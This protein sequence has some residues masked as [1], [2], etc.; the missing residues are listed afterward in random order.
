VFAGNARKSWRN[1][2]VNPKIPGSFYPGI[3]RH[4][5]ERAIQK[6]LAYWMLISSAWK[7]RVDRLPMRYWLTWLNIQRRKTPW[8]G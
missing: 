3:S 1:I 2:N 4:F 8:K 6:A 5:L 7:L